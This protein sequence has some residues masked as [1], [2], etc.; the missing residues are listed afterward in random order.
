M[1]ETFFHE[2]SSDIIW[3]LTGTE[4]VS[5]HSLHWKTS[6]YYSLNFFFIFENASLLMTV[7]YYIGISHGMPA[8]SVFY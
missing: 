7:L 1:T 6:F 4:R 8:D 2:F 5:I 3:N